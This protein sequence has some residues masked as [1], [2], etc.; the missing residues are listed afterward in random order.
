MPVCTIAG[1][2]E[3]EGSVVGKLLGQD[4]PNLG[5]HAPKG[6]FCIFAFSHIFFG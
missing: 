2:A 4:N 5:Y 1:T 6:L 3:V